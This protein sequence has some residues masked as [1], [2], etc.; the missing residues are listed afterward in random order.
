MKDFDEIMRKGNMVFTI[1]SIIF[2]LVLSIIIFNADIS[3]YWL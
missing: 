3:L 2:I 1:L